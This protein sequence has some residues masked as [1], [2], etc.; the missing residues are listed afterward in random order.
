MGAYVLF[1]DNL[2]VLAD[3]KIVYYFTFSCKDLCFIL[4]LHMWN[5]SLEGQ[6][7][8]KIFLLSSFKEPLCDNELKQ[9]SHSIL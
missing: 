4:Y 8:L 1:I 3:R 2:Q 7:F 5:S 9:A 6:T